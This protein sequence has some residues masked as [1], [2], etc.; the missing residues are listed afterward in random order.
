MPQIGGEMPGQPAARADHPAFGHGHD[1]ADPMGAD[2]VGGD[3][4]WGGVHRDFS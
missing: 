3:R 2:A 4:V 1:Q